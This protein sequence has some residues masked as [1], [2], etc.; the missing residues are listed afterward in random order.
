MEYSRDGSSE[1]RCRLP[2]PGVEGRK[3]HAVV[4]TRQEMVANGVRRTLGT[5]RCRGRGEEAEMEKMGL[6]RRTRGE[7]AVEEE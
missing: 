7:R 5:R 1:E 3:G 2:E 6:K 4:Q